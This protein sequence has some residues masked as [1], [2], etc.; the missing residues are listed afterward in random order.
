MFSRGM[1]LLHCYASTDANKAINPSSD[2]KSL[3]LN[4]GFMDKS[5]VLFTRTDAWIDYLHL[6]STACLLK[7]GVL[8]MSLASGAI[9]GETV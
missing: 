9:R 5:S 4:D 3:V 6:T 1:G 7:A 2:K 8:M